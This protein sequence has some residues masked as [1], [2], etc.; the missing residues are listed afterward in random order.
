MT[1]II[2]FATLCISVFGLKAQD[3]WKNS[4]LIQPDSLNLLLKNN[5]VAQ[6][7]I[8]NIGPMGQIKG[9]KWIG[10]ANTELARQKIIETVKETEKNKYIVIYC[11]CCTAKNC[12]NIRPAFTLLKEKGFN[13][14]AVLNIE[15]DLQSDWIAKSYPME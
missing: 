4:E 12:P 14:V 8:L 9:A 15:H 13:N 10:G 11:G 2:I 7:L 6:P 3:P 5:E 1:K